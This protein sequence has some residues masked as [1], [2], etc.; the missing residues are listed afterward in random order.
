MSPL[1]ERFVDPLATSRTLLRGKLWGDGDHWNAMELSIDLHPCQEPAPRSIADGFGQS[2][3]LDQVAYLQVL[4]GNQIV[5]CDE[6]VGL[7]TGKILTL[8]LHLEIRLCQALASFLAICTLLVFL[9]HAPMHPLEFLFSLA[10]EA[11]IVYCVPLRVGIERF[12]SHVN[13]NLFASG[14]MDHVPRGLHAELH[15]VAVGSPHDA[16]FRVSHQPQPADATA[17]GEGDVTTIAILVPARGSVLN[18]PVVVLK[19]RV[20]LLA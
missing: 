4:I 9:R 14:S 6:R 5:R 7:F 12:E 15:K 16:L 20:A 3:V 8:P 10:Q 17:V 2:V 13:P 11:G 1:R 19:G 18:A